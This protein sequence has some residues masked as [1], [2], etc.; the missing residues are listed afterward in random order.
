MS[1]RR[2]SRLGIGPPVS[3][4]ASGPKIFVP[5]RDPELRTDDSPWVRRPSQRHD[6][7]EN[8]RDPLS[9][10]SVIHCRWRL[11]TSRSIAVEID[12]KPFFVA[13][14]CVELGGE[15]SA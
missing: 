9:R 4:T 15:P 2:A 10:G 6:R 11:Q 5:C 13:A 14:A 3:S 1:P 12:A 7:W 8:P